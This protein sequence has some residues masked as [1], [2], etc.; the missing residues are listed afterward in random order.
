MTPVI[1]QTWLGLLD[2]EAELRQKLA[3]A[4]EC[5]ARENSLSRNFARWNRL[6]GEN[7]ELRRVLRDWAAAATGS[8]KQLARVR[9]TLRKI[10]N[11]QARAVW[12]RWVE[13]AENKVCTNPKP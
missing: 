8:R 7:A 13:F 10:G 6:V 12:R 11:L 5:F 4:S 1:A 9:D 3:R 2:D